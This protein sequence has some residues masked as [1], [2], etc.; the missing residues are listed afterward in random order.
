M[1]ARPVLGVLLGALLVLAA[2]LHAGAQLVE[3]FPPK[4]P[5]HLTP[6]AASE[7]ASAVTV[8]AEGNVYFAPALKSVPTNGYVG[9]SLFKYAPDGTEL[10]NSITSPGGAPPFLPGEGGTKAFVAS[11]GGDHVYVAGTFVSE[12][13]G[14]ITQQIHSSDGF[15][16][17]F[18]RATC[19]HDADWPDAGGALVTGAEGFYEE[20]DGLWATDSDLY[21]ADWSNGDFRSGHNNDR[22]AVGLRKFDQDGQHLWTVIW[23]PNDDALGTDAMDTADGGMVVHDVPG[24]SDRAIYVAGRYGGEDFG[25]GLFGGSG[26]DSTAAY[27]ARFLE[28]GGQVAHSTTA[29][30]LASC[31]PGL[32]PAVDVW[33]AATPDNVN[34]DLHAGVVS[35][36]THLYAG[37]WLRD[38]DANVIDP[39]VRKYD[40]DAALTLVG[41]ERFPASDHGFFGRAMA[42]DAQRG[43][44]HLAYFRTPYVDDDDCSDLLIRSSVG[45]MGIR[46][47]DL[48]PVYAEKPAVDFDPG[49]E[50]CYSEQIGSLA[51]TDQR[52]FVAGSFDKVPGLLIDDFDPFLLAYQNPVGG[53]Q[54]ATC[55]AGSPIAGLWAPGLPIALLLARRSVR[56]RRAR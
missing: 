36:G 6:D 30:C 40:L 46:T 24:T 32:E 9:I 42:V 28:P 44:L 49:P 11:V 17:R 1:R 23:D 39:V 27:V 56:R 5:L 41:D 14:T 22:C 26:V 35:D 20:I 18:D 54:P 52:L 48:T 25:P 43:I 7:K 2:P 19:L 53:C 13:S 31:A 33:Q 45:L 12:T 16:I 37:G 51:L 38:H 8:D 34:R 3:A 4:T 15:V 29:P 10:C 47:S 55:T 50:E 21:L